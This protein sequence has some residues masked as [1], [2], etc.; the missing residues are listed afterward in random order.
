MIYLF[1]IL[2]IARAPPRV[3]DTIT[4]K[5]PLSTQ[6]KDSASTVKAQIKIQRLYQVHRLRRAHDLPQRPR[7]CETTSFFT[8]QNKTMRFKTPSG[9]VPITTSPLWCA[10]ASTPEFLKNRPPDLLLP[11]RLKGRVHLHRLEARLT[12]QCHQLLPSRRARGRV[13]S[14]HLRIIEYIDNVYAVIFHKKSPLIAYCSG[15]LIMK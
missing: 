4:P 2:A 7:L 6:R 13:H 8:R 9:R 5:V 1:G 11:V 12:S 10:G 14:K 3:Q 15:N